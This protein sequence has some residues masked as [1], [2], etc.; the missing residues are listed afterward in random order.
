MKTECRFKS[1]F[2]GPT[3]PWQY[4]KL[5]QNFVLKL[6]QRSISQHKVRISFWKLWHCIIRGPTLPLH[7]IDVKIHVRPKKRCQNF[8]LKA[9]K[10]QNFDISEKF[11]LGVCFFFF[12]KTLKNSTKTP[13]RVTVKRRS[14]EAGFGIKSHWTHRVRLS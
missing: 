4:M 13:S 5:D 11:F 6:W 12:T 14:Y 10:T 8:V 3:L 9:T 2:Q 7:L 1:W